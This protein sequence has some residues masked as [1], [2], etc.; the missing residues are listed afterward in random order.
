MIGRTI[1]HYR[2]VEKL[3]GGGM[4][5]VY[6][7][8]DTRLGRIVALKFLP[9]ELSR[10]PEA[11][12]RFEVE[13]RSASA[14]DHANICTIYDI[15]ETGDGRLFLAMAYYE[16]ETLEARLARGALELGEAVRIAAQVAA[17]LERAHERG[18]L[19]RDIKP[20]NLMI[21]THGEVKILDFGVAK[22]AGETGLT[23]TGSAIGTPRYMAPEQVEGE[24]VGPATDL[25]GVGAV[26]Y[27]M[28]AGTHPF[29]RGDGRATAAA[30]L[31]VEPPPVRSVRPETPAALEA[32]VRDLLAKR[33]A[34]RPASAAEVHRA[35]RDLEATLEPAP[36]R[37]FGRREWG[38][39]GA[40]AAVALVAATAIFVLPDRARE[41]A[42]EAREMLPRIEV[43]AGEGR[44]AE[45]Y[46]LAVVAEE[47]LAP[48]SA[49]DALLARVSDVLHVTSEPPG[50]EVVIQR[51]ELAGE[52][53]AEREGGG[54]GNGRATGASAAPPT[55]LGETPIEGHRMARGDY[56]VRVSAEG[57]APQERIASSG[58]LRQMAGLGVDPA[59]RLHVELPPEGAWPE[60]MLRVPGG[61]YH[62]VSRSL[63][64]G[65]EAELEDFYI[66]RYE[67]TNAAYRE[68]IL[69]G[70]YRGPGS[71]PPA[72]ER[73][74]DRTGL[75]GPR[76]WRN[77]EYPEGRGRHPVADVSWYEAAAY[78]ASRGAR[79]PTVY[80]WEKAARDGV[81]AALELMM[82]WGYV[83]A[84]SPAAGRANFRGEG[85]APV[86]AF[87]FGLSPYGA[88]Q[89]AGNVREWV[90]NAAGSERLYAG[91]SWEDPMYMFANFGTAP[92]DAA[93]PTTGFR[94]A[95]TVDEH[96]RGRAAA[97][98]GGS[99]AGLDDRQGGE[100]IDLRRVTPSY[101]PV[102]R[103]GF[104]A[105][106]SHY[107]YDR[108]PVEGEAVERVETEDWIRETVRFPGPGEAA[109][110]GADPILAYLYLPRRAEPPYQTLVF[111]PGGTVWYTE[112]VPSNVERNM[113]AHVKAGRAVFSVVMKGLVGRGRGPDYQPPPTE[114]VRFRD[115]IVE[116]AI[117]LRVGLD[118]LESRDDIDM[119]GLAYVGWSRGAAS[120]LAFAGVDDRFRAIVLIGGGID[121]RFLPTLPEVSPYH[122]AAHL[123]P[124]K[125]LVNG[126][127][128][129]EHPWLTR[130]LPLW[131]LLPEPKTLALIEGAGHIVPPEVRVPTI[132]GWLDERLG[133]AR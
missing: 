108:R 52:G 95:V 37:A 3:G 78:C 102:D 72:A 18:I 96:E 132:N 66:D 44:Y 38:L 75:P 55:R 122:F 110:S 35:L 50:A 40:V 73:F 76:S 114:S 74:V 94:C 67:I 4:G 57:H 103:V 56:L 16:G 127:Q 49:V 30:I 29:E 88:H 28:L 6:R 32:L 51:F 91:G 46:E 119:D 89:M 1:S 128:D 58:W 121:E 92:P 7:A 47:R 100:P 39:V 93:F 2:I 68:F 129:E 81:T 33:P 36:R 80:E 84:R 87:P 12:A 104:G 113:S 112:T 23:K 61:R 106:L 117:E 9:P 19:H 90:H 97:S 124:P 25:W 65:L 15:D 125:L 43:L 82:P 111:V 45:A 126:R 34:D 26:L 64:T 60:G 24:R 107:R 8:E 10:D 109:S 133:P 70:G 69:A 79:L 53:P 105:I 101:E 54:G 99:V 20:A 5:V 130:G 13:A 62:L 116:Q 131:E 48:D 71:G 120:R 59:I 123:R 21:T 22:L 86:D 83:G 115:E 42:R 31:A 77:Q 14:L 11:R 98:T 85:T 63:P 27:E 41:R 118:Y 17:G